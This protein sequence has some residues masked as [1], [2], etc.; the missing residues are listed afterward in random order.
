MSGYPSPGARKAAPTA[1]TDLAIEKIKKMIVSGTLA[2]GSRL[3]NEADFAEQLGL[4]RN[5]LREAVRALTA[6][7]ILVPKQGAGTYV[8]SLEPH[9]LMEAMAF[10]ADVSNGDSARQLLQVRRLLEP[11]AV[12][13]AAGCLTPEQL[14]VL[15]GTLERSAGE[16]SVER[17]VELDIEFHR[18]IVDSVGNPVLSTLLGI[19]STHTQRLRIARGTHDAPARA[20]A[21]REHQA[22]LSALAAR[23]AQ[24]AACV[25]AVHIAAVEEWLDRSTATV[26]PTTPPHS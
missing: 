11:Q 10:A 21:H 20:R 26:P 9:L 23:D 17:F 3:P 2:P 16:V 24:L 5:S 7:R 13:Q 14:A 19:L 12:A 22:I 18:I 4:S 6:M 15:E 1:V 25:A 8:S